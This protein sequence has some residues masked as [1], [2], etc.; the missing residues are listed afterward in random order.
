MPAAAARRRIIAYSELE[1][2]PVMRRR[3]AVPADRR[4]RRRAAAA[5][6]RVDPGHREMAQPGCR[7][8]FHLPRRADEQRG[9]R[10][11]PPPRHRALA[12][13]PLPA[14]PK[15]PSGVAA[16]DEAGR[17]LSPQAADTSSLAECALRRQTPE[18]GAECPNWARSDL[19]GG[20]PA[21]GVREDIRYSGGAIAF[22]LSVHGARGRSSRFAP[23]PS[24]KAAVS[25][26]GLKMVTDI[27]ASRR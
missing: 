6:A 12:P 18:V 24:S 25:G 26:G 16:D 13:A 7:R 3:V 11:L 8:L 27:N 9:D 10:C 15:G 1:S 5:L 19:C 14:Q 21:M 20:R 2:A 17:R 23:Q 22:R 4:R